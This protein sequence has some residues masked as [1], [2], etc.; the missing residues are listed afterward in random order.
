MACATAAGG[1]VRS[2]ARVCNTLPACRTVT[3]GAAAVCEAVDE[4]ALG[5]VD[6]K[7]A[8]WDV[9]AGR[10]LVVHPAR[11]CVVGPRPQS[12]SVEAV[13][14][15]GYR[16]ESVRLELC[17]YRSRDLACRHLPHRTISVDRHGSARELTVVASLSRCCAHSPTTVLDRRSLTQEALRDVI[18]AAEDYRG[19]GITRDTLHP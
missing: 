8:W 3:G 9:V 16:I 13:V 12:R 11:R 10:D 6:H 17:R 14:D 4:N 1:P 15:D 19:I 7:P 18:S 2:I 5:K